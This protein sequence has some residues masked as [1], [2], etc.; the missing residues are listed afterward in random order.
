MARSGAFDNET[1]VALA[2]KYQ[3]SPAQLCLRWVLQHGLRP[4]PK[5]V[6]PSRMAE[7]LDV[8]DFEIDEEDMAAI[9]ALKNCG[10]SCHNPDTLD[11]Y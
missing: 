5:S 3:V 8:Y 9:D 11:I 6:T 10:G 4:I 7:N 2:Q 1:I